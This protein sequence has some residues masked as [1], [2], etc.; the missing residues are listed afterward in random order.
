MIAHQVVEA[1]DI[2]L[3][4]DDVM[5]YR[6]IAGT[7]ENREQA[8]Q[9]ILANQFNQ[10][11]TQ[12]VVRVLQNQ[13]T[14]FLVVLVC[15]IHAVILKCMTERWMSDVM[16][17]RSIAN[18]TGILR[19]D[20]AGVDRLEMVEQNPCEMLSAET[21]N[22]ACVG[23]GWEHIVTGRQLLDVAQSLE[24]SSIDQTTHVIGQHDVSMDIVANHSIMFTHFLT[25]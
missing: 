24:G 23:R 18:K 13:S 4:A 3:A 5:Q 8:C 17:E 20:T 25:S 9:S 16:Q 11:A 19:T 14:P 22:K 6:Q 15:R 1:V 10:D 7:I 21:V 12:I 2:Q